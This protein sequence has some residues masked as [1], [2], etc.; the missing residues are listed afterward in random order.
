MDHQR[1]RRRTRSRADSGAHLYAHALDQ[2]THNAALLRPGL[3]Y[4]HFHEQGWRI[5]ARFLA[6]NYGCAF[7]GVG[8][9]DE[10]PTI[11]THPS[12][13]GSPYDRDELG[14]DPGMVVCVESLI[15]EDGRG[16]AVNLR[17][18]C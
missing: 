5:P 14:L 15:A 3:T 16:E 2:I 6:M 18:R 12:F 4:R 11:R 10:Y 1:Q 9:A 13:P 7:H 8:M 17:R